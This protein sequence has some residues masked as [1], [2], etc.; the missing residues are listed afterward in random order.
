MVCPTSRFPAIDLL[1]PAHNNFR[2][3]ETHSATNPVLRSIFISDRSAFLKVQPR[4]SLQVPPIQSFQMV[5]R[6]HFF[7]LSKISNR[8]SHAV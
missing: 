5:A 6:L 8:N 3:G 1:P 2:Y 7:A 4:I